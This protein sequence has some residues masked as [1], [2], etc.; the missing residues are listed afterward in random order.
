MI[1]VKP[2]PKYVLEEE[3]ATEPL[4]RLK[5]VSFEEIP[6]S[7]KHA[8]VATSAVVKEK[9]IVNWEIT[10]SNDP[11][12]LLDQYLMLSKIRLTS[13]HILWDVCIVRMMN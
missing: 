13:R 9:V 10:P 1:A 12:K 11:S 6:I 4:K 5:T 2:S 8:T 3:Y 7:T